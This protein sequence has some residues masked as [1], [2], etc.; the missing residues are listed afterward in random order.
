M[1]SQKGPLFGFACLE[2][3]CRNSRGMV[4]AWSREGGLPLLQTLLHPG[5]LSLHGLGL[6]TRGR[7]AKQ[8]MAGG[9]YQGKGIRSACRARLPRSP[10]PD[11][12]CQFRWGRAHP[13]PASTWRVRKGP[14]QR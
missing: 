7:R 11:P 1:S 12:T 4:S 9:C 8:S 13:T 5:L 14:A 2:G 6:G 3:V 10:A